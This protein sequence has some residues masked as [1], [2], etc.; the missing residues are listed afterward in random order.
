MDKMFS[1]LDMSKELGR[2][3]SRGAFERIHVRYTWGLKKWNM[4]E[5]YIERRIRVLDRR[6]PRAMRRA[7]KR[8]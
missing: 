2:R 8:I 4:E 5:P 7:A 6:C 3:V 1:R